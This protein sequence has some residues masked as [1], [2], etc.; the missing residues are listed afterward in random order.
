M[1]PLNSKARYKT[2]SLVVSINL[3]IDPQK[4]AHWVKVCLVFS[5]PVREC[6]SNSWDIYDWQ[7]PKISP[8]CQLSAVP[9]RILWF[10]PMLRQTVEQRLSS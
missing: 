9:N 5:A 2:A 4:P 7:W 10:A 3:Q 1:R 8:K 6:A